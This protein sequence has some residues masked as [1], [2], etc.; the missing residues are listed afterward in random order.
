MNE[1]DVDAAEHWD[2]RYR[3]R[4]AL[5]SG[6]VNATL[7]TAVEGIERDRGGAAGGRSLD[8]GCGEGGDVLW[9]AGRG[10]VADGVDVSTVA[11][12]RARERAATE[13][14]SGVRFVAQDLE[15]W[16]ANDAYDLV[17]ASF[18]QS[19]I[20][21]DREGVIRRAA[22]ALASGGSIVLLSHAAPPPW[23]TSLKEHAHHAPMPTADSERA[24]LAGVPSLRVDRADVVLRAATGP[25]GEQAELEDL[26]VVA[27]KRG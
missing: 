16:R 22:A 27:C 8:L 18:F 15:Q 25:N 11:I 5:W 24:I 9:L 21:L 10:W 6:N 12:E 3:E 23:A 13:G 17:T 19:K 2:D 1:H 7:A 4:P 26:L 14:V 20:G